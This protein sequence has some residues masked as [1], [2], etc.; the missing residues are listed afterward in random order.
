M[1][2]NSTQSVREI[3]QQHPAAVPVFEAHGIDYCCGG[4]R[5]LEEACNTKKIPL[6]QVISDLDAALIVRPTKDD[7]QWMTSSLRDLSAHIVERY[8]AYAKRELPRLAALVAKVH[9]RHG[10]MHPELNQVHELVDTITTEVST[11]MLKEE[12][13]LFPRICVIERAAENR[14]SVEPA[15]FGALI[16]PIRHMMSDHDDTGHLLQSVRN[17]AHD[18]NLPEDACMSYR[19]LYQGLSDFEKDTHRHIHLENNILFPRALDL[20]KTQ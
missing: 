12:Q 20:E 4:G 9:L 13:V 16:N 18:Y 14:A 17:L 1:A 19:A 6:N 10:H 2:L 15:F 11:H 3:V 5:S 7:A 8:H